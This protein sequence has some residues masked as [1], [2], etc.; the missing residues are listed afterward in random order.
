M[1]APFE[2]VSEVARASG[3]MKT[4]DEKNARHVDLRVSTYTEQLERKRERGAGTQRHQR[5]LN[6]PSVA[7]C[8]PVALATSVIPCPARQSH[9][10]GILGEYTAMGFAGR[11]GASEQGA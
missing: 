7:H 2:F 3:G 4:A 10:R 6:S 5:T 11:V 1:N 9:L 8:L